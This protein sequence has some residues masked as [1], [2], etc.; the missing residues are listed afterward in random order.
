MSSWYSPFLGPGSVEGLLTS[1][2]DPDQWRVSD[3]TSLFDDPPALLA[4]A[5]AAAVPEPTS[6]TLLASASPDS[7]SSAAACLA[8][9]PGAEGQAIRLIVIIVVSPE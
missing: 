5:A 8:S 7:P 1:S 9:E 4:A 3:P 2:A 6:L